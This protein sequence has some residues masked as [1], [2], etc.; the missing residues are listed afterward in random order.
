MGDK[1]LK[2]LVTLLSICAVL[3]FV[4]YLWE[5]VAYILI[6]AVL[7]IIGSPLVR[8]LTSVNVFKRRM[9]RSVA[10]A[11][12]LVVMWLVAGTLC[13]IFVPLIY[14][15]LN[16]LSTIDWES[17]ML[18]IRASLS[19]LWLML[20]GVLS[21]NISDVGESVKQVVLENT[22]IDYIKTFSSLSSFL[23]GIA[24]SLFSVSFITFY[25]M[26]EDG[27]FYRLVALFFPDRYRDNI[28][29]A[30]DS[31]TALLSRYFGG[32]LVESLSLMTIISVVMM[33]FGMDVNDALIIGLIMGVMNVIPYAGPVIGCALSLC[34]ALLNPIGGDVVF[35]AMVLV[36]VIVIVKVVDDF[37]IQPTLYSQRVQAH[38][39]EVFLVILIAG[40]IAGMWGMLLAIPS[41]TV[42]RVFAREFFSEYSLVRKLTGQMTK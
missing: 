26:K 24:I 20:D 36:S 15:K 31:I 4:W 19:E 8:C 35:T 18:S 23:S 9:P 6:S 29:H 5:V 27:L 34:I 25:F 33:L 10:A 42:L 32:L 12:T 30:L 13:S 17:V 1:V 40:H 37:V 39:L 21:L 28:Y 22:H 38:P 14:D 7:A 2:G 16:E 3:F 11:L 41:Y